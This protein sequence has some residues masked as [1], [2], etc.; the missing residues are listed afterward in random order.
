MSDLVKKILSR[1]DEIA[2]S[3]EMEHSERSFLYICIL[4]LVSIWAMITNGLQILWIKA[5]KEK[6]SSLKAILWS[7][8]RSENHVSSFFVDRFS[9]LNHWVRVGSAGWKSLFVFYNYSWTVLPALK[10]NFEGYFIRFW[11]GGMENRQAVTNRYKMVVKLLIKEIKRFS[12]GGEVRMLS[13]ASG[14]AQAVV[15]AIQLVKREDPLLVIKVLLIDDDETALSEAKKLVEKAKLTE[16]FSFEKGSFKSAISGLR[17]FK[18]Q[19]VE[20]IGFLDYL[21][22]ETAIKL[23]SKIR[24][25]LPVGGRFFTCNIRKNRE[26]IF[27]DWV[28][29]WPMIYRESEDL[30][31]LMVEAGF[32]PEKVATSYEPFKIHGIV[33]CE[34]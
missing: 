30:S 12:G 8:G 10:K 16:S 3:Y 27:L 26:K 4:W 2:E 25:S 34:K 28:L 5:F 18:P 19:I 14:S 15:R 9:R 1:E 33:E 21:P 22:D 32:S 31:R 24:E 13:I 11:I 20:M 6:K 7:I 23:I 29:L 17:R